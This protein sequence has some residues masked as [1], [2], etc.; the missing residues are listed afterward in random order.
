MNHYSGRQ[1]RALRRGGITLIVTGLAFSSLPF[2]GCRHLPP[3]AP[4][5]AAVTNIPPMAAEEDVYRQIRLFTKSLLLIRQGYVDGSKVSYSNLVSSALS[6]LLQS[7][8]PYS[9]YLEPTAYQDLKEDTQGKFGGL[10]IQIGIKDGLLTVIAPM[11]DTPAARAG[12]LAGDKIVE[13]NGEKADKMNLRDAIHRLRGEAGSPIALKILRNREIK[14]FS[15]TRDWI[16]VTSVKGIRMLDDAIGYCRIVEFSDPTANALQAA[17]EK[18]Q[19]QGM[20]ALV[21]DLRNNP[22][23]LLSAAIQVSEKF[24]KTGALIVATRG[25]DD[26]PRQAPAFSSGGV[27]YTDIPIA[28]LVN[29]GSASASEIVA[30]ALQDNKRAILV[31]ETTFGKGSVQNVLPIENGAA[32]RLTTAKYYTP[33]GRSIHEKGIE[34][35]VVVAV[36][37]EEWQKVMI[38]RADQENPG[39]LDPKDK[40]AD[41]DTITDRQLDRAVDL[42]K[43]ILIFQARKG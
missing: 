14:D 19:A 28:V 40:P 13:I 3:P 5:P 9:Q 18:L 42:L 30:G 11:E 27:H 43:G 16:V 29:R 24:L 22:G 21:L 34:P 7:L 32:L 37:P 38:K 6:G 12:I 10:G 41:L 4:E 23:G 2:T 20:K 25:R 1:I 39:A 31:G 35:D 26:T 17:I 36:T 8:D 15:V 33:S